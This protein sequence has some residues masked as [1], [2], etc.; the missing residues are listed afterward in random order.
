MKTVLTITMSNP[1][2]TARL[3]SLIKDGGKILEK[4]GRT[5]RGIDGYTVGD[6]NAWDEALSKHTDIECQYAEGDI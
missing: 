4:Q 1:Y 6:L 3:I 5:Q 2:E